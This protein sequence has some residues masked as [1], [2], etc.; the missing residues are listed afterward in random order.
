MPFIGKVVLI[1]GASAGIGAACA[2]FFA[3]KGALLALVGQNADKFDRIVERIKE[4]GVDM[5]P[6]III[7][8][9]SV[10]AER[11]MSETIEK[12]NHLDILIN[13]AGFAMVGFLETLKMEDYDSIMAANVS[14]QSVNYCNVIELN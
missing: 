12:Y 10:D 2:E 5:E 4:C 3:R 1:N 13:N 8:D 7:A 6:L 11:I 14:F 9:V